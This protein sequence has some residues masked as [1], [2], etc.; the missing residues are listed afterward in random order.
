MLTASVICFFSCALEVYPLFEFPRS[1]RMVSVEVSQGGA[2]C[3]RWDDE[4]VCMGQDY[5]Q[6][7]RCYDHVD[8]GSLQ[9][10]EVT[11]RP[12]SSPGRDRGLVILQ[13]IP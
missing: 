8:G 11:L 10:S 4:L 5:K 12:S 13:R 6:G 2:V 9:A 3:P 7:S 1:F